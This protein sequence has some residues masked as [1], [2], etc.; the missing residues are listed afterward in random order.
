M[1]IQDMDRM[2]A[3]CLSLREQHKQKKEEAAQI[4]AELENLQQELISI[5]QENNRTSYISPEGAF[6]YDIRETFRTP[7]DPDSR[8]K[9]FAYLK[10][11]GVYDDLISVNATTLNSWAKGEMALSN[12]KDFQIPGL[13]KSEPTF[14]AS[15]RKGRS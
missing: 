9:F 4:Y 13:V 7:K 3:R 5:L 8:A 2:V 12:D 15:L 11:K 1:N 6:S 10:E 14:K